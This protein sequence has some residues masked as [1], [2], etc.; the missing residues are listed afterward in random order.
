MASVGTFRERL[1][2]QKRAVVPD[3]GTGIVEGNWVDQFSEPCNIVAARGGEQALA[4]RLQ[5]I[6]PVEV[7]I[8]QSNRTR[9]I[10]TDWRAINARNLSEVYNIHDIRDPDGRKRKHVLTCSLGAPT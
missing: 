5:N 8:H 10:A 2:F 1:M 7:E 3:D 6:R 9:Q 4:A